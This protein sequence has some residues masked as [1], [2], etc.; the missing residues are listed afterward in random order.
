MRRAPALCTMLLLIPACSGST[1]APGPCQTDADCPSGSVCSGGRCLATGRP[2]E[3]DGGVDGGTVA[4]GP[5]SLALNVAGVAGDPNGLWWEPSN[6]TLYIADNWNLRVLTW[7]DEG[8]FSVLAQL[9]GP[10]GNDLGGLTRLADGTIVVVEFGKGTA[11]SVVYV[12]PDGGVGSVPNL[13]LTYRRLGITVAPDGTIYDSYFTKLN[14]NYT[15]YVAQLDVAAGTET[16]V[17]TTSLQ[18]PVGVL[19][20]GSTLYVSDQEGQEVFDAPLS[21]P[22]TLASLS[23]NLT[24]D[25]LSAGPSGTIFSGSPT[26][27]V[28][29]INSSTGAFTTLFTATGTLEPRGTAYD[30][31]NQRLFV[32]EHDSSDV[33]SYLEIYPVA[34]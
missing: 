30:A 21:N 11:G 33:A 20:L 1:A 5:L 25:L 14:G 28:Y 3:E 31:V 15:G 9:P 17:V 22:A 6:S 10:A 18:E 16:P 34:E 2:A 23:T 7:T 12:S 29:Q 19:A 32:A 24:P 8:G 26:G 4:R 13:N 27:A